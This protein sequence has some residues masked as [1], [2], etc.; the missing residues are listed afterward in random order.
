MIRSLSVNSSRFLGHHSPAILLATT[1][2]FSTTST[3]AGEPLHQRI[4][5]LILATANGKPVSARSDDS[6]FLR[7]LYLDFAGRIPTVAET[8][9]FLAD[10]SPRKRA[11]KIDDLLK[12]PE[13]ARRMRELFHVMLMER[14]G[15]AG[16][17]PLRRRRRA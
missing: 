13:Y 2:F 8:R 4:D 11:K 12:S 1:L 6:E 3:S 14:L 15:G 5:A 7:R 16:G 10:E 17:P 9:A